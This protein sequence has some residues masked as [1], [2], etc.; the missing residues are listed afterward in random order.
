MLYYVTEDVLREWSSLIHWSIGMATVV[1]L[2]GH[3][4][5]GRSIP[6]LA[7]TE[8]RVDTNGSLPW[9]QKKSD[10]YHGRGG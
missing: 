1:L 6:K 4:L 3:I 10:D 8:E 9:R 5:L 7:N 2:S